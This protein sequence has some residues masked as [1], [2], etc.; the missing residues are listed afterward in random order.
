M[1]VKKKIP[2]T[3][4]VYIIMKNL[5][6]FKRAE[7]VFIRLIYV[8]IFIQLVFHMQKICIMWVNTI[9]KRSVS[10]NLNRQ[11]SRFSCSVSEALRK[12][13]LK[14]ISHTPIDSSSNGSFKSN[15]CHAF[16]FSSSFMRRLQDNL[17]WN[18]LLSFVDKEICHWLSCSSFFGCLL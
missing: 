13:K 16:F 14:T 1:Q 9:K 7:K 18:R 15:R 10:S 3:P 6:G 12:W 8:F 4:I 17:F 2:R 5:F 11:V